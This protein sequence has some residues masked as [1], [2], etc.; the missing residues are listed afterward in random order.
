MNAGAGHYETG[1]ASSSATKA[2][3]V[4][5]EQTVEFESTDEEKEDSPRTDFCKPSLMVGE[6]SWSGLSSAETRK[7]LLSST[8][9]PYK[10]I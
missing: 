6:T 5:R 4:C 10:T 3:S 2:G 9:E 7:L 8:Y 1:I